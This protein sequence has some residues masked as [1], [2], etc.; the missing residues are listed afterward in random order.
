MYNKGI[1]FGSFDIWHP[2]YSIMIKQSK[3]YCQ[4]LIV[5]L[6]LS[7]GDKNIVNNIHD[8]FLVLKSIE[9]IDEIAIYNTDKE[10]C[11]LLMFY[12]PDVRFLGD[13]YKNNEEKIVGYSLCNNIKFLNRSHNYSTTSYKNKI[14]GDIL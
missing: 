4:E 9:D 3:K 1:L 2:G 7:N 8:R 14:K 5:G 11:N 13:D 6:Q 12:N 10:L